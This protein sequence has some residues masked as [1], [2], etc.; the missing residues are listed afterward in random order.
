MALLPAF[1]ST[2]RWSPAQAHNEKTAGFGCRH[3]I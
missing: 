2:G 3:F 1:S